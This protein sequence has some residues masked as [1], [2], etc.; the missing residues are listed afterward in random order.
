METKAL[1]AGVLTNPVKVNNIID[2]LGSHIRTD[3]QPTEIK[4]VLDL[5]Q[6]LPDN[7]IT[8]YVMDTSPELGLL[9]ASTDTAAGYISYP[10]LGL[11]NYTAIHSWFQKNNPDPLLI[12]EAPLVSVVG[13]GLATPK[14]LASF[15]QDLNNYGFTA[16]VDPI[17][18]TEP[19][20][21]KT[22]FIAKSANKQISKQ[23]LSSYLGVAPD[24][25]ASYTGPA[26]FEVIYV[27]KALSAT[28]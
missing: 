24:T 26:D 3:L 10:L 1:T 21:A 27:P 18:Y 5:A 17:P 19:S 23:Y 20:T 8:T 11:K 15:A 9:T 22:S 14:Q 6:Q 7:G 4:S 13:T 28:K 16:T 25:S 2:V 12:K